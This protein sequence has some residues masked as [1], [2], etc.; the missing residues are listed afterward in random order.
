MFKNVKQLLLVKARLVK[1]GGDEGMIGYQ[2]Q[3]AQGFD[4]FVVRD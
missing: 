1:D 4:R 3:N 2:D